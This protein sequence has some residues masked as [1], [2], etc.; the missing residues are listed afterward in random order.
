[1]HQKKRSKKVYLRVNVPSKQSPQFALFFPKAYLPA[2]H[3]SQVVIITAFCAYPCGHWMHLDCSFNGLYHPMGHFKQICRLEKVQIKNVRK[4]KR[5]NGGRNGGRRERKT[6]QKSL[7]LCRGRTFQL[8][9][10]SM[11]PAPSD[12]GIFLPRNLGSMFLYYC[13]LVALFQDCTIQQNTFHNGPW[14]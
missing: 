12:P 3:T 7:T 6:L 2:T 1:M 5:N 4:K 10:L 11:S 8:G 9:T 14:G 13:K